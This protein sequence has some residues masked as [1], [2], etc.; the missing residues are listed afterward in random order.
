MM[1]FLYHF[2]LY[3]NEALIVN[4]LLFPAFSSLNP[5]LFPEQLEALLQKNLQT[6]DTLL[7]NNSVFTWETLM[8]P[9]D[10]LDDALEKFWSPLA[11]LHAVN[12]SP[13]LRNCYEACLP[14]LSAYESAIGHNRHLYEALQK[15]DLAVLN[16]TQKKIIEDN[17]LNF[18]L[19]GVGLSQEKQHRFEAIQ[20]RL[21]ELNNQFE[22]NI[23]DAENTFSLHITDE[24]R[25]QGL[26]EHA[27]VTAAEVA[28]KKNVEGW[29]F[30]LEAPCYLAIITYAEDR[31]LREIL[32]KAW[33]TRAS[34]EG[35]GGFDNTPV[36]DEILALRH[37]MAQLLDF[38]N[39]AE[40]SLAT[41]MAETPAEVLQ[42]LQDLRDRAK[43]QAYAELNALKQFAKDTL[44]LE[45]I[46]PWDVAYISEKMSKVLYDFSQESLRAYFPLNQV[47]QGLI[48]T[49]EKLYGMHI[50]MIESVETWHTDV[51][52][53][54]IT[55]NTG[56]IRGYIYADLFARP[57]KRGGAWMDSLQS[58]WIKPDGK[59]QLP[60]ATL[61]CNFAKTAGKEPAL[62]HE[63]VQTLFHEF[64]HCL[65][66]VLTRVDYLGASGMHGVEWDAV[67]L[68]SQFFENWCWDK[69]ALDLLAKHQQTG[70]KLPDPVFEKLQKS[71]QFQSALAM[72]RQLEFSLFDFCIH[73][74]YESQ[75]TDFIQNMLD[76]VRKE[77][78]VM[79]IAPYNRFQNS[80]SHIFAGGYA[81]GYYSY[82]WAEVLSSDAFGLFEEKGIF[83]REAGL[84]FLHHIL[85]TG[86]SKKA[87]DL[88]IDFRGKKATIEALLRHNGIGEATG[89][90]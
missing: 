85:E 23:L 87:I 44:H 61:T 14:K 3:K 32:H 13:A 18:R 77:T 67:E 54:E 10:A 34:Q 6:I 51:Q 31:N 1:R 68:P 16:E 82:K 65:Q 43:E 42:F 39:Y 12:N 76:R 7:K 79:P 29:I 35:P 40:L 69:A 33:Q 24:K 37:E 26:P 72:L 52:C 15:L 30:T 36:M 38:N 11:H 73:L 21:A 71:R 46:E 60:I 53:Y 19:S 4:D 90:S 86:G 56:Q 41:K 83:N 28:R 17:L 59:L 50:R 48:A 75:K 20:K 89:C 80:F 2:L 64:G 47:M 9:L 27:L 45:T 84:A 5:E 62:S 49:V 58:R 66:H 70:E 74:E 81:A 25:L 57:F 63:E 22:N 88:Y 8:V 55:D 78:S